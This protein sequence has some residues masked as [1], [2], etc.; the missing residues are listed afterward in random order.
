[1]PVPSLPGMLTA[2]TAD[3]P[4][5]TKYIYFNNLNF[6]EKVSAGYQYDTES[7]KLLAD[8]KRDLSRSNLICSVKSM[9]FSLMTSFIFH[10]NR[11]NENGEIITKMVSDNWMVA[12]VSNK[13]EFYA[14]FNQKNANLLEIDE[15]MR[16]LTETHLTNIFFQE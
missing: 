1:M 10:N 9:Y 12:K 15:E 7:Y 5:N 8:L 2:A 6:A 14:I 4:P 13:R 16:K 3:T 11:M